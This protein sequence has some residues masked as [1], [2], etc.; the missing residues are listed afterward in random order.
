MNALTTPQ[1]AGSQLRLLE[2]VGQQMTFV[3]PTDYRAKTKVRWAINNKGLLGIKG[4]QITNV[5]WS[6]RTNGNPCV[7][8]K[9]CGAEQIIG[10]ED[11]SIFTEVSYSVNNAI[12]FRRDLI[13]HIS[14]LTELA[15]SLPDGFPPDH[16]VVL[17]GTPPVSG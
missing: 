6:L 4:S 11:T 5:K 17:V 12:Q 1:D 9:G 15:K 13:A 3:D 16:S 7:T 10:R 8:E 2:F 14:N